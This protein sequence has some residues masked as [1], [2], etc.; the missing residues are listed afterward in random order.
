[1]L[2]KWSTFTVSPCP[3]GAAL[4]RQTVAGERC[5]HRLVGREEPDFAVRHHRSERCARFTEECAGD[6]SRRSDGLIEVANVPSVLDERLGVPVPLEDDALGLIGIE[7]NLVLQRAGVLGPH[8]LHALSGQ[9][10]ELLDLALVQTEP[11]DTLK[12]T[13]RSGLQALALLAGIER[14]GLLRGSHA[15]D[16]CPRT[17]APQGFSRVLR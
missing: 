14:P 9:A 16:H 2:I 17:A 15:D 6:Q 7:V 5:L 11:S 13:H 3:T 4:D 1:V 10:L 12:L 8:D